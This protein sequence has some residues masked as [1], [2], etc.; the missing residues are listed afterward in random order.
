MNNL[1][2]CCYCY[3][4]LCL[5]TR[6]LLLMRVFCREDFLVDS[7]RRLILDFESRDEVDEVDEVDKVDKVDTGLSDFPSSCVFQQARLLSC[8][9]AL[10]HS[11]SLALSF[12][13][14]SPPKKVKGSRTPTKQQCAVQW[15]QEQR[16]E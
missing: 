4:L 16:K 13:R 15:S 14:L 10:S 8:S 7:K 3:C 2:C 5:F 6:L 1:D 11:G 9:L 12:S